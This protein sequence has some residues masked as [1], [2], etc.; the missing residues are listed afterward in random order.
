MSGNLLSSAEV[1]VGSSEALLQ[2]LDMNQYVHMVMNELNEID[3]MEQTQARLSNG[4]SPSVNPKDTD[5]TT[6][7]DTIIGTRGLYETI[8]KSY[9]FVLTKFFLPKYSAALVP[10]MTAKNPKAPP[11]M[12]HPKN[13]NKSRKA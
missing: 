13:S 3:T 9:S 11:V 12:A 8:R 6:M 2:F 7:L 4:T 5:A 10:K 1:V